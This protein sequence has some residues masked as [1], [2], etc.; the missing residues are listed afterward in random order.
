MNR[1]NNNAFAFTFFLVGFL[2]IS[3]VNCDY[4][5]SANNSFLSSNSD[6]LREVNEFL[7]LS[8][9]RI[10]QQPEH[11]IQGPRVARVG[12]KVEL[13]IINPKTL[14]VEY[15]WEEI[16]G[17]TYIL[18]EGNKVTIQVNSVEVVPSKIPV[19]VLA[20][21]AS[22]KQDTLHFNLSIVRDPEFDIHIFKIQDYGNTIMF[23]AFGNFTNMS[24]ELS[25]HFSLWDEDSGTLICQDTDWIRE[26]SFYPANYDS[27][28][29]YDGKAGNYKVILKIRDDQGEYIKEK[30]FSFTPQRIGYVKTPF[31]LSLE[32]PSS[33]G[34]WAGTQDDFELHLLWE[35][36]EKIPFNV[37]YPEV[38]LIVATI[39]MR[40]MET[41]NFIGEQ[42]VE[43]KKSEMGKDIPV[44]F[45]IDDCKNYGTLEFYIKS[46]GY[47]AAGVLKTETDPLF[48]L[49]FGR[50]PTHPYIEKIKFLR[51]ESTCEY[52]LQ[53]RV[54]GGCK[55][56]P[57][58]SDKNQSPYHSFEWSVVRGEKKESII[59]GKAE[60]DKLIVDPDLIPFPSMMNWRQYLNI[61]VE[62]WVRDYAGTETLNSHYIQMEDLAIVPQKAF[63]ICP[64][65][66]MALNSVIYGTPEK[67]LLKWSGKDVDKVKHDS[68]TN[69]YSFMADSN[70]LDGHVYEL[71]LEYTDLSCDKKTRFIPITIKVETIKITFPQDTLMVCNSGNTIHRMNPI[72]TG[73]SGDFKYHWNPSVGLDPSFHVNPSIQF[74]YSL[75]TPQNYQLSIRDHTGCVASSPYIT[76][77]GGYY[78]FDVVLPDSVVVARGENAIIPV[79][80]RT[81]RKDIELKTYY[82]DPSSSQEIRIENNTISIPTHPGDNTYDMYIQ[83]GAVDPLYGC[84][85]SKDMKVIVKGTE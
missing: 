64:G 80:T 6:E 25:F 30:K 77:V 31:L 63:S 3:W 58:S 43:M 57:A 56:D 35:E 22:S 16:E 4:P 21:A 27:F 76:L 40:H 53:A 84:R 14:D 55:Y 83:V 66:T 51:D 72:I 24:N 26:F 5:D 78:R 28:K 12:S 82:V 67:Y 68:N 15:I 33:G 36:G 17:C 62:V 59:I 75:D 34:L 1:N 20:K 49:H 61:D 9:A 45:R 47:D 11:Y 8:V 81:Q 50:S 32:T 69:N 71:T 7:T 38:E 54:L 52:I 10:E 42:T 18:K 60:G 65:K 79:D 46:K 70:A 23:R 44:L 19:K 2:N 41:G 29:P 73:G 39:E 48:S 37:N 13:L 74:N 85:V